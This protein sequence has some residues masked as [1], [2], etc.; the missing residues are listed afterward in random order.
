MK[1]RLILAAILFMVVL[2]AGCDPIVVN[3]LEDIAEPPRGTVTLRSALARALP[4]QPITFDAALDGGTIAL[5]IV[6]QSSGDDRPA[7]APWSRP[8]GP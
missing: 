5:S 1:K 2:F 6:G 3:S 7:A 4:N 8:E